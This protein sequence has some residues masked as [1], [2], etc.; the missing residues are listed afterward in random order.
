MAGFTRSVTYSARSMRATF[1]TMALENN[2]DIEE[3]QHAMGYV[4][5]STTKLYDRRR[6]NPEEAAPYFANY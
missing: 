4:D 5:I 3:V 6:H 2:A 1:A